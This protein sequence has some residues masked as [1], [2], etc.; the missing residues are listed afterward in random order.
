M[1]CNCIF[2]LKEQSKNFHEQ[3]HG[4]LEKADEP[5]TIL[6][7][8]FGR[9]VFNIVPTWESAVSLSQQVTR[10]ELPS[11]V[12]SWGPQNA[13]PGSEAK[14]RKNEGKSSL[15]QTGTLHQTYCFLTC[16]LLGTN[17]KLCKFFRVYKGLTNEGRMRSQENTPSRPITMDVSEGRL[18]N[19]EV[20]SAV[21]RAASTS[22]AS[23]SS[24][25][26]QRLQE[27]TKVRTLQTEAVKIPSSRPSGHT[28]M[29]S[30]GSVPIQLSGKKYGPVS[31]E[32]SSSLVSGHVS[33]VK[34]SP[35]K[36]M[37]ATPEKSSKTAK[38]D[39]LYDE[40]KNPFA[41]DKPSNPFGDEDEED[42]N[43]SLNPFAE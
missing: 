10:K 30:G 7:D 17:Y 6:A 29:T 36:T 3:F 24:E 20:I 8:Y 16:I 13:G 21:E 22:A 14:L 4:E 39:Q 26:R 43:E 19:A 5:F 23:A 34:V 2:L 32:I 42:Y 40:A 28:S 38:T 35:S 41:D 15:N 33:P 37:N 11:S 1:F 27:G 9:G 25:A 18:R 12:T 31:G